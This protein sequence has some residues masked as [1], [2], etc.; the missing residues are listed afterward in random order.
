MN[1]FIFLVFPP[2]SCLR[3]SVKHV[4]VTLTCRL[5]KDATQIDMEIGGNGFSS[6]KDES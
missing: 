6:T 4:N 3:K 2:V 5:Q 1:V